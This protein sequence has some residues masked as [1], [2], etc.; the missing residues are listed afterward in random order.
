[1]NADT[2]GYGSADFA[3]DN[4]GDRDLV[5]LEAFSR[6]N[7]Y[8]TTDLALLAG[9]RTTGETYRALERLEERNLVQRVVRLD[10]IS[11]RRTE[12]GEI[13]ANAFPVNAFKAAS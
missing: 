12:L 13:I 6:R 8:W 5:M 4:V 11:W 7:A 9:H 10:P 1:M 3:D 2:G